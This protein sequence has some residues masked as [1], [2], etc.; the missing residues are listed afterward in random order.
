M[1]IHCECDLH[2]ERFERENFMWL[3]GTEA[4]S[5]GPYSLHPTALSVVQYTSLLLA[6]YI[7]SS[8]SA[9]WSTTMA[10]RVCVVIGVGPGLGMSCVRHWAKEGYKV[11]PNTFIQF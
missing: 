9:Q 10:G 7:T 5:V 4:L 2:C 1:F 3:E 11:C 6:Q 8:G